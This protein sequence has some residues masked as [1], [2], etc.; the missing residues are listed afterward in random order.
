M[1]DG[2]GKSSIIN[3]GALASQV[4]MSQNDIS[5]HNRVITSNG[6][7]SLNGMNNLNGNSNYARNKNHAEKFADRLAALVFIFLSFKTHKVLC[8]KCLYFKKDWVF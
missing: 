6:M 2:Q 7:N 4:A 1:F 3:H 8:T 5:S